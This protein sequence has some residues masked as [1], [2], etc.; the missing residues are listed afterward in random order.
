MY[1]TIARIKAK[2]GALDEI[3]RMESGRQP[4]G[5][6]SS[7]VFQSDENAD[8]LWLVAIF[9][10]KESYLANADS[11][12]QDNEYRRLRLLLKIDP[13]WHDGEIVFAAQALKQPC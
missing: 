4:K 3:A 9:E 13:E 12:E 7:Y 2:E 10:D 8:E 6:V 1:G 5:A 11:P